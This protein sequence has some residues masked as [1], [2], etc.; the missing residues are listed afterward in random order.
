M[1]A[2]NP[3]WSA[4]SVP[5]NSSAAAGRA[6]RQ[7]ERAGGNGKRGA[8]FTFGRNQSNLG[9]RANPVCSLQ[10]RQRK[11]VQAEHRAGWGNHL[12]TLQDDHL[13]NVRRVCQEL[14]SP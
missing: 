8:T 11:W 12:H 13:R 5:K 9:A 7:S 3:K 1:P 2:E 6:H 10:F 4:S 14:D